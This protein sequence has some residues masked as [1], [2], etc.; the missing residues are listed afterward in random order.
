M[1]TLT[2]LWSRCSSS[3]ATA[4]P[5]VA[6]ARRREVIAEIRAAVALRASDAAASSNPC[7]H[8]VEARELIAPAVASLRACRNRVAISPFPP[9]RAL[10]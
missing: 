8:R 2:T 3:A 9:S 7:A 1:N 6:C 5:A 4:A 10:L